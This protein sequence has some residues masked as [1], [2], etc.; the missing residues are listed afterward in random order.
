MSTD[1]EIENL[2]A[3][4]RVLW[5]Q[6][7]IFEY[8]KAADPITSGATPPIPNATF[9]PELYTSGPSRVIPLDLSS[10]LRCPSPATTPSL[11][12]SFIRI[13]AGEQLVT[14]ANA[15]SEMFYVIRG[16]GKTTMATGQ[17]A[18]RQGDIFALPGVHARHLATEDSALYKVDD[19]PL[20]T[21][22]GAR[23]HTPRF[24]PTL[25]PAEQ[26]AAELRRAQEE[27]GAPKR[28]RVSVLLANK[29]CEQTMTLTQVLW[30]MC[31]TI[32]PD[33][34]QLPHR[35]QSV[36]L[37]FV[38]SAQPGVYTLLGTSLNDD[39][40]INNPVRADW[41]SGSVFV[42]PPGY[43]HEH[44]NESNDSALIMPVQDA[45]LHTYLRTL[46]IQFLRGD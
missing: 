15:T 42:T 29:V 44:R 1:H 27:P 25:Y 10:K 34:R 31:G 28:S 39:G 40:R 37:D 11:L 33:T 38:I 7:E 43:W 36:A 5:P 16:A 46:D 6:G 3:E 9:G 8:S 18:W 14:E 21:Y 45:G 32:L 41:Q 4:C 19:S 13:R 22:L 20:L 30:T 17:I 2:A 12:A 35:H 24:E 23:E 26:I